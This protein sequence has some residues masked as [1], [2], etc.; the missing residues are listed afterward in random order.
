[1]LVRRQLGVVWKD[2]RV[3]GWRWWVGE[4]VRRGSAGGVGGGGGRGCDGG[5]SASASAS[6]SGRRA[7][8]VVGGHG[9]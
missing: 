1:M 9:Y 3:G 6:G 7:A 5:S 4:G 8:L 2:R